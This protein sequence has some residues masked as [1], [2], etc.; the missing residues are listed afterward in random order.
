[1]EAVS[2]AP[3]FM[4]ASRKEAT[5]ITT[6]EFEAIRCSSLAKILKQRH[7][8]TYGPE[9]G[10]LL[11]DRASDSRALHLALRVDDLRKISPPIP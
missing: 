4:H 3:N 8:W 7:E 1:M 9:F 6:P 2:P 10:S 11:S 5:H